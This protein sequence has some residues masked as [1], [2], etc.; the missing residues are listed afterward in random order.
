[1]EPIIHI[2]H[3]ED[4]PADAQLVQVMLAEAGLTCRIT[5]AQTRDEFETALRD[6][7]TEIILA[8]YRLPA[9]DGMSALRLSR[10]Q[11][12]DIPFIFVSGAM[13]EEAAIEA[14]TQGATDYVLK[15]NLSRLAPAVQRALQ[16]ARNLR[17]RRR[18]RMINAARIHL[19]QFAATHCLDEL[20]EETI[21][22]AENL[23]ESLIGFYHFVDDDQQ[24]LTLQ[25]WSTR[26]KAQFC[27][28][29]GKG[30]HYPIAEAGVW[31]DCVRERK[32]VVHNDYITLP[33]RKGLPEGHAKVVRELVVP[34][35]RGEKIKAILGVGNK[36]ADYSQKDVEAMSLLADLVWE[37]TERKQAEEDLYRLNQELERRVAERTQELEASHTDLEKAYRDLQAAHSRMLQQEKMA[38]IGQLAAGVAHEIN[39]PLAF[40]ISNLGTFGEYSRELAQF[41]RAQEALLRN[42][43]SASSGNDAFV[44]ITRLRESMDL[45]FILEDIGKI[46]AE[47]LDGGNRMKQIVEN[48]KSFARLDEAE[49]KMTD[50]NFSPP[51]QWAGEQ[52]WGFPSSMISSKNTAERSP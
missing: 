30:L 19:M 47:S 7:E 39:N 1:M 38:S 4:D 34:V 45:D 5:C 42:L 12:S 21:N 16:E 46:V 31:V 29:Q 41:H 25:N 48:L 15:H 52:A 9:Y 36:P 33:H 13:G 18:N 6:A 8:D 50:I 26:T 17:E 51:N 32:P 24:A 2:I 23:T 3:L 11:R 20:I 43:A 22:Q 49:N 35:M 27:K 14:L 10:E 40:I 37:I 28:A 44:E